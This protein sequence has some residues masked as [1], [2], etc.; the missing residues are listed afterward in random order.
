MADFTAKGESPYKLSQEI[1]KNLGADEYCAYRI[2]RTETAHAQVKGQVDKYKSMGFTHC[3]FNAT[4]P[5]DD[6]STLDGELFTLDEIET[7]IPRHPNCECGF[8]LEVN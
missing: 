8:L 2:A 3:R 7:L 4:D 1:V 5:C 6:C